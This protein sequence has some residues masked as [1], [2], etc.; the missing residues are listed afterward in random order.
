MFEASEPQWKRPCTILVGAIFHPMAT[1][2]R[3]LPGGHELSKEGSSRNRAFVR[4]TCARPASWTHG[5]R[6][7][8]RGLPAPL[9]V[10]GGAVVGAGAS[11]TGRDP[12]GHPA[13]GVPR[14]GRRALGCPR[15]VQSPQLS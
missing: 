10:S 2:C 6:V 11:T 1:G 13:G 7:V 3:P 12:D 9:V 5:R 4:R 14:G 8:L 15:P